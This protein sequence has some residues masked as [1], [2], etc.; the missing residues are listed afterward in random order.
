MPELPRTPD[1]NN[2]AAIRAWL[3]REPAKTRS[4][5]RLIHA[6]CDEIDELRREIRAATREDDEYA[7]RA[8]ALNAE[9]LRPV[10][11]PP[12]RSAADD[13]RQYLDRLNGGRR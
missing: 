8:R 2:T 6:L 11:S 13:A 3:T 12:G 9:R 10:P 4:T 7:R 1:P 5:A